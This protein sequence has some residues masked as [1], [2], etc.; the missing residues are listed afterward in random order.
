M[1]ETLPVNIHKTLP[2]VYYNDSTI[3]FRFLHKF[4]LT[5]MEKIRRKARKDFACVTM[6]HFVTKLIS[7]NACCLC[8]CQQTHWRAR[9]IQDEDGLASRT[10]DTQN[11]QTFLVMS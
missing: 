9:M 2:A 10:E 11:Y 7:Q 4:C 6:L 3:G 8:Y 5:A 1:H